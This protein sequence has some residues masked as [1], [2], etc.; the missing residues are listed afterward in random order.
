L[1]TIKRHLVLWLMAEAFPQTLWVCRRVAAIDVAF[2]YAHEKTTTSHL[3]LTSL[4]HER[5]QTA[6]TSYSRRRL[7]AS[8]HFRGKV[9]IAMDLAWNQWHVCAPRPRR[10]GGERRSGF[11]QA[12]AIKA[13]STPMKKPHGRG[14]GAS[15]RDRRTSRSEPRWQDEDDLACAQEE[16]IFG[17]RPYH[18]LR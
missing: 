8:G 13:S 14:F 11:D 17:G 3:Q 12:E 6:A 18:P 7:A 10:C 1:R 2:T 15:S 16:A 5:S 9:Y 4:S